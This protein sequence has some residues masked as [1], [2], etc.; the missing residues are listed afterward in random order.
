MYLGLPI[1]QKWGAVLGVN[2]FSSQGY[3]VSS[4]ISIDSS[5]VS[6]VFQGDGTVNRL[7]IGTGLDLVKE[8]TRLPFQL[9]VTPHI[10]L[11]T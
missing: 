5:Q 9:G 11:A 3:E 8:V 6:N 2:T 4:T 1:S 10:C 7:F